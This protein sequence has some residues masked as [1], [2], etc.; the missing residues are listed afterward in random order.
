M[1]FANIIKYLIKLIKIN[2]EETKLWVNTK[3]NKT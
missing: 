1:F 3:K 2:R